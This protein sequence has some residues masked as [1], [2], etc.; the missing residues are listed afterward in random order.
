LA[1]VLTKIWLAVMVAITLLYAFLLFERG[2]VLLQDG[3]PIAVV[4]GIAILVFPLLAIATIFYEIRFGFRL[5]KLEKLFTESGMQAPEYLLRPSGRAEADS[6]KQVFQQI[7]S[8]LEK[9]ENN[10]LLWYLLAD[11]YDKLG[12]R[13]RARSAA[14]QAISRA[15]QAD[16]L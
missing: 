14:R 3:Q 11:S 15:K 2:W 9:D 5:A 7:K 1:S 13:K 6:G 10:F 16:A 4:M 12:D 8:Q